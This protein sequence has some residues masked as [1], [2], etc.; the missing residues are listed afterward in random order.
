MKNLSIAPQLF[1]CQLCKMVKHIQTHFLNWLDH[2]VGLTFKVLSGFI[3]VK[4]IFLSEV[5]IVKVFI[6]WLLF[7]N[8]FPPLSFC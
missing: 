1:K 5:T 3:M 4:N 8:L 6:G 2:F 7:V